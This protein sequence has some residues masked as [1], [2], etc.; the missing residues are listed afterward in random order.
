MREFIKY[1]PPCSKPLQPKRIEEKKRLVCTECGWINYE[2]P[3]PSIAILMRNKN[4]EILLIK[5]G[6]EPAKGKWALPSGFV[7]SGETTEETAV[8]ELF[9]ETGIK[10]SVER[11]IG[12][13]TEH[14]EI[15]GG[16]LVIGY[17]MN[18]ES[19]HPR[20]GSDTTDVAFFPEENIPDIPFASHKAI[21]KA[22]F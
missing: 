13:Y 14:T 4:G 16:V 12:V 18:F 7:E 15:H 9:E 1:C 3:T 21:I 6:V 8:R 19:G 5:R 10:G 17:E 22:G 11:L 2:N 20:A